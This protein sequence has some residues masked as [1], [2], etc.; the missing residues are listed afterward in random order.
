MRDGLTN[1]QG[2]PLAFAC[3]PALEIVPMLVR[4]LLVAV[5]C[6][7]YAA[8]SAACT[9]PGTYVWFNAVPS[10]ALSGEYLV[11]VGDV[12]SVRVLSH[13]EMTTRVRVRADGRIALPIIGEVEARGKRPGAL[14]SEVE[15]RFK[16]YI[17]A[18]NVTLNIDE[19]QPVHIAV[20]GEV[21]HPGVFPLDANARL[22]DAIALSGGV[23]EYASRDRIFVVRTTP[24]RVR[25]R[26][27][28]EAVIRDDGHAAA[29]RLHP[30]DVVVVE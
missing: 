9:G 22:A 27:T 5:A 12:V 15:A 18:P 28:Y 1:G 11:S 26:F 19:T 3:S 7:G 16:E 21:A 30:D 8:E 6:L 4:P 24:E 20:L 13:E 2:N 14:R 29:F 25:I 10:E 23:T 17:V